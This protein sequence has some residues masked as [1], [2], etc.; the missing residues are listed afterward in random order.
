MSAISESQKAEF[1]QLGFLRIAGAIPVTD[2]DRMRVRLWSPLKD[3][4]GIEP[5]DPATWT[6]RQP[7]GFQGVTRSGAFDA[8][9]SPSLVA[10]LD[11][12]LGEKL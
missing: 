3:E 12:I 10:A 7:T 9:V 4:L 2:A 1:E 5:H 8:L 6:V 11:E